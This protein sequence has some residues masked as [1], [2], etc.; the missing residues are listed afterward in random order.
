MWHCVY[1][2]PFDYYAL[3]DD[4]DKLISTEFP[5]NYHILVRKRGENQVIKKVH[6]AGCPRW[7]YT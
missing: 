7:N 3:Y 4:N 5:E 1:K 6:Y 2:F